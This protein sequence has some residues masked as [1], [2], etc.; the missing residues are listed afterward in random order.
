MKRNMSDR[1]RKRN[2][3]S[4]AR[5]YGAALAAALLLAALTCPGCSRTRDASGKETELVTRAVESYVQ[6]V[7]ALP[8]D[9]WSRGPVWLVGAESVKVL[10][11]EK[12][13]GTFK[14]LVHFRSAGQETTRYLL[15]QE[16]GGQYRVAGAL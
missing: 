5:A 1:G 15:V 13:R 12:M 10:R 3:R 8:E 6:E 9:A 14:A 16:K 2:P 4:L 11:V 7:K